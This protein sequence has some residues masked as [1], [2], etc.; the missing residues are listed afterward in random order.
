MARSTLPCSYE[1]RAPLLLR[2]QVDE[3]FGVEE[4]GGVGA[5]VGPADLADDLGHLGERLETMAAL[6][7]GDGRLS[8]GPVLGASDAAHPDGALVEVRQEL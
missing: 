3:V 7:V 6:L 5:V 4:A 1:D 8:V 2:L